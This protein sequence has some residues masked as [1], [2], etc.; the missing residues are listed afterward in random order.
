ASISDNA[1]IQATAGGITLHSASGDIVLGANAS[2][3]ANGFVQTFFDVTRVASGGSVQLIAD[4]GGIT[5][6]STS[7]I[8]VSS[9]QGQPGSAGSIVLRAP[10]GSLA[11][12]GSAF[13]MGI[14]AGSTA[15][16]S[17]GRLILDA[18]ALGTTT[19]SVPSIFSDTVDVH[20]RQSDLH[21]ASN[22]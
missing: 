7:S 20:V 17:G 13:N 18:Q 19:L 9:P 8:D 5:A 16:D 11:S 6:N 2:I 1:L 15:G 21:L 12:N 10:H 14:L 22:L 3:R 4:E